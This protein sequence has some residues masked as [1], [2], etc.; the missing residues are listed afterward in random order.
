MES[1]PFIEAKIREEQA[2]LVKLEHDRDAMID[3]F[4]ANRSTSYGMDL[5]HS[6]MH[7]RVHIRMLWASLAR[8]INKTS[9]P[10][11]KEA[12]EQ[13]SCTPEHVLG[14]VVRKFS[15]A[16]RRAHQ[17]EHA[18]IRKH[19]EFDY[20]QWIYNIWDAEIAAARGNACD[21]FF[22]MQYVK[23]LYFSHRRRF[24]EKLLISSTLA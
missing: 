10:R 18:A 5:Q 11:V 19:G 21:A 3:A 9:K 1:L 15:Q 6:V 16:Y 17:A 12:K 2:L 14:R 23:D 13:K 7:L 20:G 4:I 22:D 8:I 24:K